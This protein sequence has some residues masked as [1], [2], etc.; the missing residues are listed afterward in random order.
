MSINGRR[1]TLFLSNGPWL[2]LSPYFHWR[3][4]GGKGRACQ[5]GRRQGSVRVWWGERTREPGPDARSAREYARPTTERRVSAA[6]ARQQRLARWGLW[7]E[8]SCC[9]FLMA[10]VA[11]DKPCRN[12]PSAIVWGGR[13]KTT[14]FC[15]FLAEQVLA[16]GVGVLSR[17]GESALH[18][19]DGWLAGGQGQRKPWRNRWH[20]TGPCWRRRGRGRSQRNPWRASPH[21]PPGFGK[22]RPRIV[23]AGKNASSSP[24][25]SRGAYCANAG[26]SMKA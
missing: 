25:L 13:S 3:Q 14:L 2:P 18:G 10:I 4:G 17:E 15:S 20:G 26:F 23:L 19:W 9:R 5:S 1:L 24:G 16:E 12:V 21:A 22:E 6:Q 7:P 11:G 8:R